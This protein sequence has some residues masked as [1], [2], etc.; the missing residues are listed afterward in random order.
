MIYSENKRYMRFFAIFMLLVTLLLVVSTSRST[1]AVTV[2]TPNLAALLQ[3]L[4]ELGFEVEISEVRT[5]PPEPDEFVYT[6]EVVC[7]IASVV[8][9]ITDYSTFSLSLPSGVALNILSGKGYLHVM[10]GT[11][12]LGAYY[13]ET[14]DS[15]TYAIMGHVGDDTLYAV[16]DQTT[17]HNALQ[18]APQSRIGSILN[19]F[20]VKSPFSLGEPSGEIKLTC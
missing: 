9:V 8:R 1:V 19:R 5:D 2:A 16:V 20:L 14:L 13:V 6:G 10:N 18:S 15:S 4:R 17:L 7:K 3:K 11:T 12:G